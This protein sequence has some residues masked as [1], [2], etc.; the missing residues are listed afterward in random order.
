M[1]VLCRRAASPKEA[2]AIAVE[3]DGRDGLAQLV[4]WLIRCA[5]AISLNL[6]AS[7]LREEKKAIALIYATRRSHAQ[8]LEA[9]LQ[10]CAH[11][12]CGL[13]DAGLSHYRHTE[14]C[15][16]LLLLSQRLTSGLFG[17]APR[18]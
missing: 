8:L 18:G 15:Q 12:L 5:G 11:L 17:L 13:R 14:L 1:R 2:L 4:P 16:T 9:A 7:I 3:A 6:E 10:T